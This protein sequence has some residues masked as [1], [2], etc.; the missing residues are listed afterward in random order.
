MDALLSTNE[1]QMQNGTL[2]K[3][4]AASYEFENSF[5]YK[6]ITMILI[7]YRQARGR[8]GVW[9][10]VAIGDLAYKMRE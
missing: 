10:T 6:K 4:D 1:I 2:K 5:A 3:W 7:Q 8:K 9:A